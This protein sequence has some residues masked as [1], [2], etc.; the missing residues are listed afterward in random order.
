VDVIRE[1]NGALPTQSRGTRGY[2]VAPLVLQ[3]TP[4]P[5]A[6]IVALCYGIVTNNYNIY[7]RFANKNL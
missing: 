5:L 7:P 6:G 3:M 4:L 1:L 2:W